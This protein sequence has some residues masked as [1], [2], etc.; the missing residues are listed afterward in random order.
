MAKYTRAKR[1]EKQE[2]GILETLLN[3]HPLLT[4]LT[5]GDDDFP[6]IDGYIHLLGEQDEVGGNMLKVQVKPLKTNKDGT[7]SATCSTDL[8]S[9]AHSSS[10][11]L[12][13][14]AVNP[15]EQIAYWMYLAPEAVKIQYEAQVAAGKKTAT[16]RLNKNHVIKKGVD[17]YVA[18]WRRICGHHRNTSNDRLA[19]R[20]KKRIKRNLVTANEDTLLERIRTLHDL[21]YYRT[22]KNKGEYPLVEIVLEMAR[23]IGGT[24]ASMKIAYIE[25]LEQVIHDKTADALEAITKLASDENEGVRKKA[26]EVLKN[27][28]KYNYH[29]LNA[30]GYG[31]YRA[32]LDF[33][34][35]HD[36]PT[37]IA[38][39]VLRNLL[40]PD[41]DGTSQTDMYTLT[42]HRGPL[43]ATPYLKTLRRDA[44]KLLFKRYETESTPREKAKTIDSIGYATHKSDSPFPSDPDFLARSVGIPRQSF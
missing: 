15:E 31:P 27:T 25:L 34:A 18:E 26:A 32:M 23:T 30:I 28:A 35:S 10:I 20:Y 4:Q 7:L 6:L 33:I 43:D 29:V 3:A 9:H 17:A 37:D 41:F 19:A 5:K 40:T 38:H 8:L 14:I 11:P 22:N 42:F 2:V 1:I 44:I 13:L 36:V 21:V 16:L 12:L 39:E 24:S